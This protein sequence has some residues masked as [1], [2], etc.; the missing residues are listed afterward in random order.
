MS[1]II[2]TLLSITLSL[3]AQGQGSLQKTRLSDYYFPMTSVSKILIDGKWA[4]IN[5]EDSLITPAIYDQIG[6]DDYDYKIDSLKGTFHII[7]VEYRYD[8][9]SVNPQTCC[10]FYQWQCEVR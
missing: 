2:L 8:L 10:C 3:F 9:V 6:G 1:R 4:V 7:D 5:S